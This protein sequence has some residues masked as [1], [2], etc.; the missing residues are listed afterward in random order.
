MP[1]FFSILYSTV[2]TALDLR[3]PGSHTLCARFRVQCYL[4]RPPTAVLVTSQSVQ[5]IAA[6]W[7]GCEREFVC[8]VMAAI[9]VCR[10]LVS[11]VIYLT[12]LSVAQ[13]R[14]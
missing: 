4:H 6:S 12:T 11:F 8:V 2:R 1:L 13:T 7:F 10:L 3:V 5:R 9:S 14:I